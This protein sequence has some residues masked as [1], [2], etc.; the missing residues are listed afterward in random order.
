[1][2][3]FISVGA[4]RLAFTKTG[5]GPAV[6]IV[7]GIGGHKEDW[8]A[9]ARVLAPRHTVFTVDMLGFGESSKTGEVINIAD[10]VAALVALLEA[11]GVSQVSLIGNSMGGWVAATF[12]AQHPERM[13]KLVLVDAAGFKA[14][15]EGPPPVEFY[16]RDVAA[17]INLLA[18][19]RHDPATHTPTFAQQA[20]QASTDSGDAQA[21]EAVG[22][23]M[24]ASARLE[25]VAERIN[26]PTLVLWGE[27]DGLFPPAIADLVVSH[28]R[29]ARKELIPHASH[30]PQLDNPTVF[31]RL[32][33]E[34]L[35][36]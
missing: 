20:L 11:Q 29:G 7:H 17:M 26:T 1:M 22:K 25:D 21:A 6:L 16:P 8:A 12:A 24:F 32:I 4:Q 34:F 18:H 30:F 35:G 19:V 36:S 28:I 31:F 33:T 14:M 5:S 23:G 9:T 13:S 27:N 2:T 3:S 15:F 10:Q